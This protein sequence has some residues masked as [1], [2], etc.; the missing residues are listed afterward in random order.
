VTFSMLTFYFN[1]VYDL[2]TIHIDAVI[3]FYE[4]KKQ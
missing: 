3:V 4:L 1:F 2:E